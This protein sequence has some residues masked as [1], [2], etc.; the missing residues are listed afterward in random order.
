[1]NLLELD[2]QR[3]DRVWRPKARTS[4]GQKKFRRGLEV[5]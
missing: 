4:V 1:M 5:K 2:F 3:E